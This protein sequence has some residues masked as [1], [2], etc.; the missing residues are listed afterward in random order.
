MTVAVQA[1]RAVAISVR[2][3]RRFCV[4]MALACLAVTV[5]GFA[6]TYWLLL[7]VP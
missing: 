6:P 4:G 1:G 5:I 3:S 2:A 7:F